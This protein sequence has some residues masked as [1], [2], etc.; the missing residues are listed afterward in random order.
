MH[1]ICGIRCKRKACTYVVRRYKYCVKD[2]YMY[3]WKNLWQP[4]IW[5]NTLAAL[6]RAKWWTGQLSWRAGCVTIEGLG[7]KET[8]NAAPWR[9]AVCM[10]TSWQSSEFSSSGSKAKRLSDEG[11]EDDESLERS[12][13]RILAPAQLRLFFFLELP[14][15]ACLHLAWSEPCLLFGVLCRWCY[16]S[17]LC[18]LYNIYRTPCTL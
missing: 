15:P 18:V 13:W 11:D 17:Q 16:I 5:T 3:S 10:C 1:I 14:V 8:A 6:R 4:R 7:G 9:A 2:R 12:V